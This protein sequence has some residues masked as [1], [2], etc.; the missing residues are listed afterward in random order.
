MREQIIVFHSI[1]YALKAQELLS[2]YGIR[3]S[4]M[5]HGQGW[6]YHGCSYGLAVREEQ[7]PTAVGIIQSAAI[8]IVDIIT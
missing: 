6:K 1:T 3:S 5:R 4:V 2:A 7:I 8:R